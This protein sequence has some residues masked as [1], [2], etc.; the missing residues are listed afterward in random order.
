MVVNMNELINK[1]GERIT[2]K[3]RVVNIGKLNG[4]Y[5]E[6]FREY[7]S[8]SEFVGMTQMLRAMDIDFEVEWDE[9]DN[10]MTAITVMGKR[11]E[12]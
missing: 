4:Y 3:M 5:K 9:N 12:V 11:F 8:Y 7:P 2:A 10:Q 6:N 1:I